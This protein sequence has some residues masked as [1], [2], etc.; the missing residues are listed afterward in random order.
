M[1]NVISS[2]T[3]VVN[4]TIKRNNF[5]IGVN[6]SV[7]YGP[8]SATTFWNGIVPP[9]SG[10]TVYAQKTVNGPSIRTAANDSE[11]ITISR[12]YGGTNITTV[13]DALSYFNGQSNFLVTNIDYPNI[14]T[15]GLTLMLDAGYVP[16][17]PTTGTT[18]ND[19]SG[20]GFNG[21]LTNGP[22]FNST[23]GGIISI[24]ST[25]AYVNYGSALTLGA[26]DF[27]IDVWFKNNTTNAGIRAI[28]EKRGPSYTTG[29]WNL[30]GSPTSV[31]WEQLTSS[32]YYGLTIGTISGTSW[33]N[34]VLTRIGTTV[35]GYINGISGGTQL[36]DSNDY[37]YTG[38]PIVSGSDSSANLFA[39]G[40]FSLG[41]VRIY[42]GQGLTQSQVTQNYN[43][44][45]SRF[46]L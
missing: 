29:G 28:L 7:Q 31:N 26:G 15:S 42:K 32:T 18:W 20:G 11:L 44:T 19:L 10:Y 9:T 13:Y 3:T 25:V 34:V 5:L 17:Y 33:Y 12:Q 21:T 6:T 35:I 43:A 22:T 38:V 39:G 40:D 16:S 23:N 27:A 14:V 4:G 30:R 24:P 36:N 37:N 41:S 45:K 1:P 2:G 46:G 8:T